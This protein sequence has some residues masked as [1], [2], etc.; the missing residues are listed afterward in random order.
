MNG[1]RRKWAKNWELFQYEENKGNNELSCQLT[2][3]SLPDFAVIRIFTQHRPAL[4]RCSIKAEIRNLRGAINIRKFKS[5]DTTV[6]AEGGS[7]ALNF[8]HIDPHSN[9]QNAGKSIVFTIPIGDANKLRILPGSPAKV[10]VN[11]NSSTAQ[12]ELNEVSNFNS[13]FHRQVSRRPSKNV[14]P[15]YRRIHPYVPG[16]NKEIPII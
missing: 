15:K 4:E 11:A 7:H 16:F 2:C 14:V 13:G 12:V 5:M 3:M 8:A 6:N 9:L 10:Y 1:V